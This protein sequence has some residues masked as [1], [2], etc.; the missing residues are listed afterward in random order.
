[1]NRDPF[2]AIAD[3]T[4]R[5]IID[6]LAQQE[7]NINQIADH[8]NT[9]SRQA[10]TK[11]L[12]YLEDSGLVNIEKNGREKY[13]YLALDTLEEVNSWLKKYEKFWNKK[14]NKLG[15]YLKKKN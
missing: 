10:V 4:R 6:L 14:L 1:M 12:K 13:C 15:H 5:A 3:P 2:A 9:V 7:L 11:Q 8:F